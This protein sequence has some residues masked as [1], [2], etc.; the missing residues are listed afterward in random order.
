MSRQ[1]LT[2]PDVP[3]TLLTQTAGDAR[4]PQKSDVDPYTQ[5][6]NQTRGDARYLQTANAFTQAQADAR[7]PQKTDTDPYTQYYNQTRGD[8][9]YLQTTT[10]A[11]TYL[12]QASAATTYVPL[13]GGSVL[14]GNLGPTTTATRDLGTSAVRW[15]TLYA[16][17]VNT[18]SHVGVGVTPSAW[19]SGFRA[20]QV[21]QT[22]ALFSDTASTNTLLSSNQYWDGTN[23]R[24]IVTQAASY[25]T[26]YNGAFTVA[27]APSVSAGATQTFTTRMTVDNNGKMGLGVTPQTAWAAQY[28][29]FQIGLG[30]ALWADG[31]T[32][33]NTYLTSNVYWD[34]TNRRAIVTGAAGELNIVN[35]ALTYQTAPSVAA[36]AVQTHTSRFTVDANGAAVHTT[37]AGVPL[38]I[39]GPAA[40]S[41]GVVIQSGCFLQTNDNTNNFAARWQTPSG[42]SYA[43]YAWIG[44]TV[45]LVPAADN[46]APC[47]L[48][49]L[50][51][52]TVYAVTGTINTSS[53][54]YKDPEGDL[55]PEQALAAV[56][57]TPARR[58]KYKGTERLQAGYYLEE[59]DPLFTI[60][61]DEASPSNDAGILLGAIQALAAR[62][63]ITA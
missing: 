11:S 26:L 53:V 37:S 45:G 48:G 61:P 9:R 63:G 1:V 8:A 6:Y 52:S 49:T 12:T 17:G 4:Y 32:S 51:W 19:A 10:A 62:L 36:G 30:G 24:A 27:T 18:T 2:I 44:S 5:Y 59:A 16:G 33:A 31:G 22:G 15:N 39:Q 28:T 38:T 35:G 47:G 55:D 57:R 23:N 40:G 14:T 60:G 42:T 21:G 29:A 43:Q 56:L 54:K 50:R 3:S 25:L 41:Y 58:F 7:Y 46:A 34:A 20:I 13:S